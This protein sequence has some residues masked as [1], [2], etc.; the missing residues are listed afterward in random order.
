MRDLREK[1]QWDGYML[2][3]GETILR[4]SRTKLVPSDRLRNQRRTA[5]D[6]RIL[7]CAAA[8]SSDF[9]VSE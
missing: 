7:E 4:V 2:N 9:I 1:L 5:D 6:A 3:D 8:A